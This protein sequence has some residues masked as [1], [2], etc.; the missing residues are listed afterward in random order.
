MIVC[1]LG[2]ILESFVL[3][4]HMTLWS[5]MDVFCLEQV[6]WEGDP[7]AALVSFASNA[8]A[9]LAYRSQEPFLNNRF[10]KIFW[11]NAEKPAQNQPQVICQNSLFVH[12]YD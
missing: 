3:M 9:Q 5:F 11:H 10:I 12:S 4:H 2:Y 7:Q 6:G 8:Q 1:S